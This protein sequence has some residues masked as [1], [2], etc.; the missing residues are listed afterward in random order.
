MFWKFGAVTMKR[1]SFPDKNVLLDTLEQCALEATGVTDGLPL[2]VAS[3]QRGCVG[4]AVRADHPCPPV[5]ALQCHKCQPLIITCHHSHCCWTP[6]SWPE[7]S[8]LCF[9]LPRPQCSVWSRSFCCNWRSCGTVVT[10]LFCY[11][12]GENWHII[13]SSIL[14]F[15]RPWS[16]PRRWR[17]GSRRWRAWR[18][19][20]PRCTWTR[21]D[22]G[23]P[24]WSRWTPWCSPAGACCSLRGQLSS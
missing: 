12:P 8:S 15:D 23:W 13:S 4:P 16:A 5:P 7:D 24:R 10:H 1:G 21:R 18:G 22:W 6:W 11:Q 14:P 3:P 20:A 19:R 17:T 2:R 9:H